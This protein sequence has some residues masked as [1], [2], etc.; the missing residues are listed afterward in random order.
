MYEKALAAFNEYLFFQPM[1]NDSVKVTF[2]SSYIANGKVTG[3]GTGD[4]HADGHRNGLA[5]HLAC[6]TGGMV[7]LGAKIFGHEADMK[8]AERLAE[9]C[10]WAYGTTPMG[11][12]SEEMKLLECPVE[13][14]CEWNQ[15]YW[16]HQLDFLWDKRAQQIEEWETKEALERARL[17]D[18]QTRRLEEAAGF[19]I[20]FEAGDTAADAVESGGSSASII[21]KSDSPSRLQRRQDIDFGSLDVPDKVPNGIRPSSHG[22]TST[23]KKATTNNKKTDHNVDTNGPPGGPTLPSK[24][25]SVPPPQ[26]GATQF[27]SQPQ[28]QKHIAR[29]PT[30]EQFVEQKIKNE[31]LY[32]GVMYHNRKEYILRYVHLLPHAFSASTISFPT[33]HT[34]VDLQY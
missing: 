9:G 11:V 30:H 18:E 10:V 13:G 20:P 19:N 1:I 16:Y 32:P 7:A 26:N 8:L 5:S 28:P 3:D 27:G 25:T 33:I 21:P 24:V 15:T 14:S 12:M 34:T 6:F 2:A 17:A 23:S 31:H 29:P 4:G 22:K